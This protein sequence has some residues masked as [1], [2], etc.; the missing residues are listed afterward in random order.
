[1]PVGTWACWLIATSGIAVTLLG[2]V[3]A[4]IPPAQSANPALI[5]VK[6]IGG[7]AFLI[8][9]GLA[10]FFRERFTPK[11]RQWISP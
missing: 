6:V 2:A 10:F 5:A 8:G 11:F 4:M 9:I 7:S 3:V 1:M